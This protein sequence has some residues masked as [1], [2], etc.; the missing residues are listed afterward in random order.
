MSNKL[1]D[2]QNVGAFDDGKEV[3]SLG[4]PTPPSSGS[5]GEQEE[6]R[7]GVVSARK[8]DVG[9]ALSES[10]A[11]LILAYPTAKCLND[12]KDLIGLDQLREEWYRQALYGSVPGTYEAIL[13]AVDGAIATMAE[14]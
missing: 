5:T 3:S 14:S 7:G 12:V 6:S 2:E 10:A 4:P 9:P 1:V 11:A 13:D 8:V